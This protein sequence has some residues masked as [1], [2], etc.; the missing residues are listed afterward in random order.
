MAEVLLSRTDH[1]LGRLDSLLRGLDGDLRLL[2]VLEQRQLG[3]LDPCVRGAEVRLGFLVRR[4]QTPAVEDSPRE[5]EAERPGLV[6]LGP[7]ASVRADATD[8]GQEVPRGH[9]DIGFGGRALQLRRPVLRALAESFGPQGLPVERDRLVLQIVPNLRGR[10]RLDRHRSVESDARC[11]ERVSC[12]DQADL[13]VCHVD[14]SAHDRRQGLRADIKE[15]FRRGEVELGALE[16]LFLH[17]DEALGEE[18]VG[19]GLL[20]GEGDELAL[21]LDALRR[22]LRELAGRLCGSEGLSEVEEQL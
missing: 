21:E 9:L 11:A 15:P 14:F 1:N 6:E 22:H 7:S 20:H 18:D 13:G 2:E 8:V 19:V 17:S 4:D 3:R 10:A 16:S 12:V 5:G